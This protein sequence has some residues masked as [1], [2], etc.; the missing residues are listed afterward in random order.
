MGDRDGAGKA[1]VQKT[2]PLPDSNP[3]SPLVPLEMQ[4]STS[5]KALNEALK[6]FQTHPPL[7]SAMLFTVDKEAGKITCLCQVSRM[8]P[9]R[10]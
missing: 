8:Q 9:T 3:S 7:P 6:L 2:K 10:A 1:D 4:S 5:A